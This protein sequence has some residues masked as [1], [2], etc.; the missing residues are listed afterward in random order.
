MLTERLGK[1]ARRMDGIEAY[2]TEFRSEK[3]ENGSS[4]GRERMGAGKRIAQQCVCGEG[5]P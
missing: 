1:S 3:G 4:V 2:V 5:G